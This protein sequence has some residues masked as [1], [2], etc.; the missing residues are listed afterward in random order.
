MTRK[1]IGV[2]LGALLFVLCFSA[3]AQQAEKFPGS[4]LYPIIRAPWLRHSGGGCETMVMSREKYP[5]RV[6]LY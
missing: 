6:S 3:Q 4:V 1:I 5:G 2:A